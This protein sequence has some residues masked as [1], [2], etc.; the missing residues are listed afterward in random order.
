MLE[1]RKLLVDGALAH[2]FNNKPHTMIK[3]YT[4]NSYNSNVEIASAPL[5]KKKQ[6]KSEGYVFSHE[7]PY[8]PGVNKIKFGLYVNNY[9]PEPG[10][11]TGIIPYSGQKAKG[12]TLFEILSND[13]AYQK[14]DPKTGNM[15]GDAKLIKPVIL[16][17]V[18][19]QKE[20]LVAQV[21]SGKMGS[22][23]QLIPL[24]NEA[25]QIYDFRVMMTT[26]MQEKLLDP[27]M[28]YENVMSQ[29]SIHY[30]DKKMSKEIEK[31]AMTYLVKAMN[32]EYKGKRDPRFINILDK[33]YYTKYYLPLPETFKTLIQYNKIQTD[34][35]SIFPIKKEELH[36]LFGARDLSVRDL[37]NFDKYSSGVKKS[38]LRL[39]TAT[40]A[41]I[42]IAVTNIIM[43]MPEVLEDNIISNTLILLL[44]GLN[45]VKAVRLQGQA[46]K[47]LREW[48]NVTA[49]MMD[50]Y[51]TYHGS[52]IK[53]EKLMLRYKALNNSL[54]E[55]PIFELMDR[56]MFT[57]MV[58]EIHLRESSD[59]DRKM[60][61]LEEWFGKK[62]A[63]PL[64]EVA[65]YM[66]MTKTTAPY[67][68]MQEIFQMS[69]F[70]A[71]FALNEH[72]KTT[73]MSENKRKRIVNESFVLYD[74]PGTSRLATFINKT[75]FTF[76]YSYWFKMQRAIL[77]TVIDR[78]NSSLV[79]LGL[80]NATNIDVPDIFDSSI[81]TGNFA[82]PLSN[83]VE[84]LEHVI[85]LPGVEL[86]QDILN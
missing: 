1:Q 51:Y 52:T 72:L 7:L 6:M 70:L 38:L 34:D 4:R 29:L 67:Q 44:R 64:V 23:T 43:K 12:T 46:I 30:I 16:Q 19:K 58:E 25:D 79:L 54:K 50:L 32:T 86:V 40:T 49:E 74:V 9:N 80:Q 10:R 18:E 5:D 76:F 53:D 15:V 26:A 24:I 57:S 8:I 77:R 82:P 68:A 36:I 41:T 28:T 63:T 65:K 35:G 22:N 81:L 47:Y 31:D 73:N 56:H 37:H 78:T 33:K 21:T 69:D 75:G 55:S 3:G 62:G 85:K 71:R 13:P 2:N 14:I 27:D 61:V 45:P 20:L 84:A 83:P 59:Y 11:T 42:R 39:N 48:K 17:Y 60:V 66:Y